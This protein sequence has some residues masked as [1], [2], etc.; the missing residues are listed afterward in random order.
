V[1]AIFEM[2]LPECCIKCRMYWKK[3]IY[4]DTKYMCAALNK[5][6]GYNNKA[7][8]Q[9]YSGCPLKIVDEGAK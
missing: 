6:I 7:E 8:T 9:R 4:V 1:K 2:E 5:E 3:V